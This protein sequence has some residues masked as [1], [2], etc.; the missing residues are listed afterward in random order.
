MNLQEIL[1][2]ATGCWNRVSFYV[3][4][5][6]S[7]VLALAALA[8]LTVLQWG[9]PHYSSLPA[10]RQRDQNLRQ[11]NP[12]SGTSSIANH[13]ENPANI[14]EAFDA[15]ARQPAEDGNLEPAHTIG[16]SAKI[17][18]PSSSSERQA[19]T[20]P[21]N[22]SDGSKARDFSSRLEWPVKGKIVSGFRVRGGTQFNGISIEAPEGSQVK[23]AA[24]GTVGHVG[25]FAGYGNV[26]L[27][28]HPDRLVTV[29]GHLKEITVRKGD[30]V[31]SGEAIAK[32]AGFNGTENATVYFEVR[33]HGKPLNPTSFLGP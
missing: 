14:A 4:V 8:V 23:A 7:P 27:L 29:Y 31:K 30:P 25:S 21:P 20:R 15:E 26:V 16:H 1:A 2:M 10:S 9:C 24:A 12:A 5:V 17:L 22:T 18:D 6:S 28:D 32:V 3:R 11:Q 19:T 13:R 33:S